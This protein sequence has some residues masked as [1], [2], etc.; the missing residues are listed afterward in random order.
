MK[1]LDIWLSGSESSESSKLLALNMTKVHAIAIR[2]SSITGLKPQ[3]RGLIFQ[4][5]DI[6]S[7][8]MIKRDSQAMAII[9]IFPK[10]RNL[11]A[12]N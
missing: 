6:A 5:W 3:S 8:L 4:S 11:D 10:R 7:L 12:S 2:F 1:M 9:N